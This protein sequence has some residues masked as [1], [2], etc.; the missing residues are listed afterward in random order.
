MREPAYSYDAVVS[1]S[2]VDRSKHDYFVIRDGKEYVSFANATRP[3]DLD[4]MPLGWDR[5][6][7]SLDHERKAAA[8][9]LGLAK[10]VFPELAPADKWPTLWVVIPSLDAPHATKYVKFEAGKLGGL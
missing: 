8:I 5:Y 10:S 3:A 4:A 1:T 6:E 9:A 7:A 2:K